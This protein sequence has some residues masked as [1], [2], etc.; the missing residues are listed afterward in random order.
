[1][2]TI[3]GWSFSLHES[4]CGT[5]PTFYLK[6]DTISQVHNI[7]LFKSQPYL[8]NAESQRMLQIR[9]YSLH[10]RCSGARPN[11][12]SLQ[13][14]KFYDSQCYCWSASVAAAS[15]WLW[16]S[17]AV[18]V[19]A[20]RTPHTSLPLEPHERWSG[21]RRSW[22]S[23]LCW[24]RTLRVRVSIVNTFTKNSLYCVFKH[25]DWHVQRISR[26][27]IPFSIVLSHCFKQFNNVNIKGYIL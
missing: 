7:N 24:S 14:P 26:D 15:G 20:D 12:N 21:V 3:P 25:Y 22:V 10:Q 19:P 17:E 1:M 13:C 6:R 27:S 16:S 2:A 5:S 23:F 18:A 4:T 9:P 11:S 8:R